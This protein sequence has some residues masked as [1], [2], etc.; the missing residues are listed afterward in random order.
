[1]NIEDQSTVILKL[2]YNIDCNVNIEE[3]D[4]SN[5]IDID[6]FTEEDMME[7]MENIQQNEI[8]YGLLVLM[9]TSQTT[10]LL[11]QASEA[12]DSVEEA[13][14]N[15]QQMLENQQQTIDELINEM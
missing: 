2:K 9:M 11:D 8:L 7:I 15:E 3:R 12:A 13:L 10:T 5:S 6:S 1:M 4:T 14:E